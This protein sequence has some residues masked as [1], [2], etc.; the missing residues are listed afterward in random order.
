MDCLVDNG[1]LAPVQN[2]ENGTILLIIAKKYGKVVFITDHWHINQQLV[3]KTWLLP[4]I[5][6]TMQQLE[7]FHFVNAR[8]LNMGYFII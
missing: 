3:C 7:G 5:G 4:K 1:I 8:D 2:S 6:E